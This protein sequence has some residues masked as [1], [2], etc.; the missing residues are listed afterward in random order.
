MCALCFKA[1]F[2]ISL[3]LFR[4]WYPCYLLVSLPKTMR[5]SALSVCLLINYAYTG[6]HA[7]LFTFFFVPTLAASGF[8]QKFLRQ[9][10]ASE[11]CQRLGSAQVES[12][13][14]QDPKMRHLNVLAGTCFTRVGYHSFTDITCLYLTLWLCAKKT[15]VIVKVCLAV[16]RLS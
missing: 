14:L 16:F 4:E 15:N 5:S 13:R 11:K 1:N 8:R 3:F 12:S 6:T 2:R 7:G 9:C 10:M